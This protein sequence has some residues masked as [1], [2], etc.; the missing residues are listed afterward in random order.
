MFSVLLDDDTQRRVLYGKAGSI[1]H[2]KYGVEFRILGGK[3]LSANHINQAFVLLNMTVV[4]FNKGYRCN[5]KLVQEAINSNN[6]D[7]ARELL[8]L[9]LG[10]NKFNE[11]MSLFEEI[12]FNEESYITE[13]NNK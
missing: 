10:E 2:K 13:T 9:L 6:C 3:F 4:L 8:I 5:Y 11:F 7:L 1:R 12:N